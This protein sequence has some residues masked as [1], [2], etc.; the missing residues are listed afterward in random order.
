VLEVRELSVGFRKRERMVRAVDGLSLTVPRGARVGLVGESGSGKSLTALAIMGLLDDPGV[1]V[2]GEIHL[3]GENLTTAGRERWRALRGDRVALVFQDPLAALNPAMRVGAQVVEALRL[4]RRMSRREARAHAVRLLESVGMPDP[5]ERV[6]AWPHELSGGMRQR[7]CIAAALA[8]EPDLLVADEPTTALDVTV[9]AQVLEL[10]GKLQAERGLTVLLISHD[11]E[12]VASWCDEVHV[13][14]AGQL[15]ESGPAGRVLTRPVHPYT[16]GLL[17]SL[18]GRGEGRRARLPE[19]PGRVPELAAMPH[20][21]RFHPRCP[22]A[23]DRCRT[24]VPAWSPGPE[25][26]V[27]CH[28]PLEETGSAGP[29]TGSGP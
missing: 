26:G 2:G 14:Y 22:R 9:Q 8:C 12:L 24:E 10:L 29:I 7:A 13:M 1:E 6:D 21:C 3:S 5:Q 18:P 20:G 19:I 11:L 17:Q 15:V 28:H 25:G 4:R 27:R 16:A 23:S